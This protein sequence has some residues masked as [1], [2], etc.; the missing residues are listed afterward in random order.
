MPP[1]PPPPPYIWFIWM[2]LVPP[3]PADNIAV[4]IGWGTAD[5]GSVFC[6]VGWCSFDFLWCFLVCFLGGDDL[7]RIFFG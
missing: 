1:P 5:D 6:R 2:V 7:G 4:S 3:N